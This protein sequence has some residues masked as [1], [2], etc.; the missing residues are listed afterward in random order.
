MSK[1]NNKSS[2]KNQKTVGEVQRFLAHDECSLTLILWLKSVSLISSV[3]CSHGIRT[4]FMIIMKSCCWPKPVTRALKLPFFFF[5]VCRFLTSESSFLVLI[6][7]NQKQNLQRQCKLIDKNTQLPNSV[8][9]VT[10]KTVSH[11]C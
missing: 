9:P 6:F 11:S 3:N 5:W 1:F 8:E 10:V 7:H 4:N 2:S